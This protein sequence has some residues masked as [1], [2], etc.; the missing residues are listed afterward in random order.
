MNNIFETLKLLIGEVISPALSYTSLQN[1]VGKFVI[2]ES[3]NCLPPSWFS[4]QAFFPLKI[5][6]F[7]LVNFLANRGTFDGAITSADFAY[8]RRSDTIHAFV[9][10]IRMLMFLRWSAIFHA[11]RQGNLSTGF[12]F[13]KKS[14]HITFLLLLF[15]KFSW[16][17]K[18][19]MILLEEE[20][21]FCFL[22]IRK[23][24]QRCI[25]QQCYWK[26]VTCDQWAMNSDAST[27]CFLPWNISLQLF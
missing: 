18:Q 10:A 20:W 22:I 4:T 24:L 14:Y 8:K 27:K 2:P 21:R 5:Q 13:S 26:K 23:Y 17:H 16:S 3:I 7:R 1:E 15:F 6:F 25:R 9:L 11:C 19:F 12:L